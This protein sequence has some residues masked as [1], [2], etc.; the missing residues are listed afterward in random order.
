MK[1][2]ARAD[3]QIT[4][5]YY[6]GAAGCLVVYDIT[7]RASF[8]HLPSWLHDIREQAEDDA[9]IALVGNMA[10]LAGERRAVP[11]E[12]ARAFAN[13]NKCVWQRLGADCSL[14]FFET[15]AKSGEVR[16]RGRVR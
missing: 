7:S 16:G 5:S 1:R 12:E 10:D 6:R 2:T 11:Q 3:L 8:E 13:E 15:S 4:R 9:T 14:L